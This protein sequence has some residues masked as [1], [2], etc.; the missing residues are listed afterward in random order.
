MNTEWIGMVMLFL[1]IPLMRLFA[2]AFNVVGI[3][4]GLPY[5]KDDKLALSLTRR[6][7]GQVSIRRGD[8]R[9]A[10]HY[11]ATKDRLDTLRKSLDT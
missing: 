9:L 3:L 1:L 5:S 2:I 4:T 11:V 8:E 7:L 6:V 10:A